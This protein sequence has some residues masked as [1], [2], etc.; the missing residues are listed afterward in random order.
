MDGFSTLDLATLPLPTRILLRL[1]LRKPRMSYDE[2]CQAIAELP[3]A[4]RVSLE[5]LDSALE[6][7][8]EKSWLVRSEE[9]DS[10]IYAVNVRKKTGTQH[11]SGKIKATQLLQKIE[12]SSKA[13]E[14]EKPPQADNEPTRRKPNPLDKLF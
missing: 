14:P 7:L 4:Q 2:L 9:A 5:D 1:M 10:V 3:E 11:L 13:A 12:D 8:C 6:S